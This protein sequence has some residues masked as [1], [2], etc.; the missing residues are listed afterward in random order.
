MKYF[1]FNKIIFFYLV[2]EE[3]NKYAVEICK[4]I[5]DKL[6]G[7]DPDPLSQSSISEQVKKKTSNFFIKYILNL[8]HRFVIPFVKQQILKI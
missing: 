5:R 6:D 4:R 2:I 1:S 8:S 3:R 7:S